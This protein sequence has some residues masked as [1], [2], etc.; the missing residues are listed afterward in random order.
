MTA[1]CAAIAAPAQAATTLGQTVTPD[2]PC[3]SS[4]FLLTNTT[5]PPG[6]TYSAPSA[7][8]LTSFSVQGGADNDQ[9][10]LTVLRP[11]GAGYTDVAESNQVAIASGTLVTTPIRIPVQAGDFIAYQGISTDGTYGCAA[12][13]TGTT[14]YCMPCEPNPGDSVT[15]TGSAPNVVTNISAKLEPDADNDGYGD[16]TQDTCPSD[17]SRH[18]T[19]CDTNI[20]VNNTA[21]TATA[22]PGDNVVF[23]VAVSN[24]S[25]GAAQN[26]VVTD[27]VPA[28]LSIVAASSNR[29]SDCTVD[30]RTVTCNLGDLPKDASGR[31]TLVTRAV[32]P[33]NAVNAASATTSTVDSDSSNNSASA[34]VNV[35]NPVVPGDCKNNRVGSSGKDALTGTTGGDNVFGLQGNDVI[36]GLLGNDCLFGGPGNDRL[37]GDDGNDRLYGED[38]KDVLEGGV[39]SDR[40]DGGASN[41]SLNGGSGNDVVSGGDGNDKLSGGSGNDTLSGGNGNDTIS[42][43]QGTNKAS[44]GA[45]S[46][47]INVADGKKETVNCGSG[48]DTARVDKRDVVKGCERVIR[49]KK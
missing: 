32:Q 5:P 29:G 46:D 49:S 27:N 3:G 33:G 21:S 12:S 47:T 24:P 40:L 42:G 11:A 38:G 7:G 28:Q 30:G 9:V 16:E 17:A 19:P 25:P 2:L 4:T 43:G 41:D 20:A 1:V 8:V 36:Q 45:G 22:S 18:D 10:Q 23:T 44:G 34:T 39:G 14:S 26:V 31:L 35:V 15:L 6:A 13:G 37:S 48:R